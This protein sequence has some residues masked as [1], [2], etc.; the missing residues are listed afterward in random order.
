MKGKNGEKSSKKKLIA[1]SA[2]LFFLHY[3]ILLAI[4]FLFMIYYDPDHWLEYIEKNLNILL[5]MILCILLLFIA[6]YG[7]YFSEHRDRMQ[8]PK[9]ITA[10]FCVLDLCIALSCFMGQAI[11]IYARP[12]ALMALLCLLL[13]SK[14]EAI[15][16]N[17]IF[18]I[19]LFVIDTY[20]NYTPDG[21][22]GTGI[23][24]NSAVYSALIV[25]VTAGLLAIYFGSRIKTRISI[26]VLSIPITIPVLV[27]I[28]LLEMGQLDFL[29]KDLGIFLG[30]G[31]IGGLSSTI[32][33]IAFLPIFEGIFNILT[34]FRVREL[35][36]SDAKLMIKLKEEAPGTFS[37]CMVVAQIAEMCASALGE[38]VELARAAALY[39]DM[40]KL[41]KPEC[42]TENQ[43]G[44]N[45]H[46]E[47]S[48]ELSVDI[49]RSHTKEGHDLILAHRLP[50]LF[51]DVAQQHHGTLPIKYFYYKAK[52]M[53]DGEV[54]IEDYSYPG[55]KPKSKIAAIIMIVDAAEA[56]SRALVNRTV[57]NVEKVVRE[58]IEERVDLNQF[59]DCDITMKDLD[60]IRKTIVAS[61]TGVYHHR[62]NYPAIKF[63]REGKIETKD[64]I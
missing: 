55:P 57:D 26:V 28:L 21:I 1:S 23:M 52:R 29:S 58:I 8:S 11:H 7:Y 31:V 40:G 15:F 9:M 19:L 35:T 18:G 45:V 16:W 13:F 34:V 62:V 24:A 54:R 53:T 27:V 56:A 33:F 12:A 37:H 60:T 22:G 63:G 17:F 10:M 20:T 47:L 14:R 48:P 61:L 39:H 42:F 2:G 25:S 59:S 43:S 41:S 5:Y 30:F 49:I 6:V 3:V 50:E 4:I 32:F 64:R 51:A 46:D 36:T 44:Y 38:N